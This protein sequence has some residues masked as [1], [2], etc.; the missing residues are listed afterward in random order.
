MAGCL[1]GRT[2]VRRAA[3]TGWR[4]GAAGDQGEVGKMIPGRQRTHQA[5]EPRE[6][7]VMCASKYRL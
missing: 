2:C 4:L 5:D 1:H 7:I 3:S 6:G